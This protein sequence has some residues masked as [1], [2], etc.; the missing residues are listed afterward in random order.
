MRNRTVI[1]ISLAVLALLCICAV[2]ALLIFGSTIWG[3]T[4]PAANQGEA[5]MQ[6]LK[7]G[8]FEGAYMLCDTSLQQE[9]GGIAQME[10]SIAQTGM[11]PKSWIFT[12][13]NVKNDIATLEGTFVSSQEGTL[14][15][16][17]RKVG[18]TWKITSYSFNF[19]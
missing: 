8:N 16:T 14:K 2:A 1:I 5:F 3:L 11:K 13:R 6:A 18:D 17:L 15:I 10:Q 9:I 12:S 19:K 7:A 4:A